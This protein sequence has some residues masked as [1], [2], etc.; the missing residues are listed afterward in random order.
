MVQ[1][2][3]YE[4][5]IYIYI[6]NGFIRSYFIEGEMRYDCYNWGVF[7]FSFNSCEKIIQQS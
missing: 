6:Y 1:K 5:H 3:I 7:F 4:F 2:E